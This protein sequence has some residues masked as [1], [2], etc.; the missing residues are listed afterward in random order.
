MKKLRMKKESNASLLFFVTLMAISFNASITAGPAQAHP[1]VFIE[2]R[3]E[4]IINSKHQI[5]G[6][7]HHWVFDKQY[8]SFALVGM[9]VNKDG[10]YSKEE[11]APLA[12]ENIESLHEYGFFT[13][14]RQNKKDLPLN[15]PID[16]QLS[17][18]ND[19][20]VLNFTLPLKEPVSILANPVKLG[21][22]D[23]EF[24]IA[25]LEPK[26]K[27]PVVMAAGAPKNC[28][29]E[30]KNASMDQTGVVESRL[31]APMDLSNEENKGAGA[32]FAPSFDIS[33]LAQ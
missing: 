18:E 3:T 11:L 2:S 5:T 29:S 22:Y 6:F 20:L 33:C 15:E 8:T 24:F 16:A 27:S 7:R 28:M 10:K 1:H 31:G 4:V 26:D 12:K 32:L 23:P 17:Y 21:V 14:P 25:F 9:D 30:K 13:Y 19:I